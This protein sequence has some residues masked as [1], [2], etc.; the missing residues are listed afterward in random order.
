MTDSNDTIVRDFCAAWGRG[1]LEAII[2]VFSKDAVYH[3]I[4][5][6]PCEGID[7]IRAM[8]SGFLHENPKGVEFQILH[9]LSDGNLVM[10]ERIDH[11]TLE[12]KTIAARVCGIFELSNDGKICA[13]RDY[14]D[15][16]DFTPEG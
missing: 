7:E 15:M 12:G 9:Q 13:W 10:N 5:M 11:L 1:D 8:I 16:G 14:F 3:N 6:Q 2:G 4:P